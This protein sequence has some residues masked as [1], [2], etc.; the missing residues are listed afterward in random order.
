MQ[1]KVVIFVVSPIV[2]NS[3]QPSILN[4]ILKQSVKNSERFGILPIFLVDDE[5]WK[6]EKTNSDISFL[7]G[8]KD[9]NVWKVINVGKELRMELDLEL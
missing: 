1:Y 4:D 3:V 9:K 5:N 2:G 7:H 6:D 8:I